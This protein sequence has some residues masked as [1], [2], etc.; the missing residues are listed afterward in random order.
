MTTPED[1]EREFNLREAELQAKERELKLREMET[2]IYQEQKHQEVDI[3]P[4]MYR[5]QKHN[6]SDSSI[7]K[8]GKK[9]VKFAKFAGFVVGGI[10]IIK[11]GFFVGMWITYLIM[12]GIIAAVGYQIFLRDD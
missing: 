4:Q 5:T 8:F 3:E 6:P 7:Q 12:T 2:E 10:A 9:I 1:R 11:I